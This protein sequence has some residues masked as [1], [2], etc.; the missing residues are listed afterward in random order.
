MQLLSCI[1]RAKAERAERRAAQEAVKAERRERERKQREEREAQRQA[2]EAAAKEHFILLQQRRKLLAQ[3]AQL[4]QHLAAQQQHA[5]QQATLM[6]GAV[7]GVGF[8]NTLQHG[9][10]SHS[11]GPHSG[12][13]V[14]VG[15]GV[16]ALAALQGGWDSG[17]FAAEMN[18]LHD[19]DV[20][21][22]FLNGLFLA[23]V[24]LNFNV[25]T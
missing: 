25:Y 7:P 8:H 15:V 23:L 11:G 3:Q 5:Q 16:N 1:Y 12:V 18:A 24:F 19:L 22:L 14:N 4:A 9:P 13:N 10:H 20:S 17:S 6:A 21:T 2:R